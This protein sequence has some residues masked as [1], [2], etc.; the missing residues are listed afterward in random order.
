M[1]RGLQNKTKPAYYT[2]GWLC[3]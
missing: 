1:I 2:G 3:D